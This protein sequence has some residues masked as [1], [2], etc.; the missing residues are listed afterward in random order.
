MLDQ[1]ENPHHVCT[2]RK[3]N[4]I[5]YEVSGGVKFCLH[6]SE[7][8]S[9][10]QCVQA[11]YKHKGSQFIATPECQIATHGTAMHTRTVTS[12]LPCSLSS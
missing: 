3:D 1:F 7:G 11:C 10:L 12:P 9:G 6:C 5:V 2:K 8:G 4:E